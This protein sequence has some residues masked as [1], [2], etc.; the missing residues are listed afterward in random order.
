MLKTYLYVPEQLNE[1]INILA[2]A[3]K[4]SKAELMRNALKAGLPFLK[5]KWIDSA[6][7]LLK[8]AEIG[9]KYK[10]RG[11]KDASLKLDEYLWDRDWNKK[12]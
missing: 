12:R 6:E 4:I 10:V 11:P 2:E 5:R 3:Q 9:E 8:V 7:V 1:E